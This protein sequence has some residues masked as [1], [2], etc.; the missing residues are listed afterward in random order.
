MNYLYFDPVTRVDV[1]I[2]TDKIESTDRGV[3]FSGKYCYSSSKGNGCKDVTNW[4]PRV[5]SEYSF[6]KY[7]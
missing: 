1:K 3:T 2:T 6:S 5:A 4:N 7:S